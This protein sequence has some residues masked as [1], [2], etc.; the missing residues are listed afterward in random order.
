MKTPDWY[1]T[2]REFLSE[3]ARGAGLL[4][5]G[6]LAMA[7]AVRSARASGGEANPFAYDLG[8]VSKTDPKLIH[9]EQAA[10]FACGNPE[11]R[12]I[13]VGPGDRLHVAGK[14]GVTVL[15]G[16]GKRLSE[17]STPTPAR[18]VAAAK[19]GTVYVGL[20]DHVEVFDGKGKRLAAWESPGK[21]TWLTGLAATEKDVFA[22]DAGERVV[23]RYDKSGKVAGRIGEKDRQHNV[24]G[25][26]VPSPYLDVAVAPD[27]LL[28]VNN[29]G[30][31]RV[32]AYT[33]TG[34]LEQFWGKPS[35]RIDGF[36]GCCNPVALTLL[37]DGRYVT[38]EKGLPRVKVYSAEG[39]FECVVA[40][41][42]S[43]PENARAGAA[44]GL[45]DCTMGGLDAAVD[46]QGRIYVL[47]LTTGDVSVMRRKA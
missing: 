6:G 37:P 41:V 1:L 9:Y 7:G 21:K 8:R 27:G 45:W 28:R 42:E 10:R 30:R 17:I 39:A 43:F 35:A 34:D 44:R 19:D 32:E 14:Q 2:R 11:P 38:C 40:G 4:A 25:L 31:H 16:E 13:V 46:A 24:P 12:R 23:L 22:A 3:G 5:A 29:F 18:C 20:Q 47:D 15:D 26:I 33:A 36:C